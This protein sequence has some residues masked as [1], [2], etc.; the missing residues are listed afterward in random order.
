MTDCCLDHTKLETDQD[1]S[2]E[3]IQRLRSETILWKPDQSFNIHFVGEPAKKY[4]YFQNFVKHLMK[5]IKE[6]T[7]GTKFRFKIFDEFISENEEN[8]A[9]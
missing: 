3:F 4:P 6:W 2:L 7:T 5:V 9:V 8:E 1:I